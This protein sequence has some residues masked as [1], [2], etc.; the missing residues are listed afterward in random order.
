MC[1][2]LNIGKLDLPDLNSLLAL[3]PLDHDIVRLHICSILAT[4]SR[5]LRTDKFWYTGVDNVLIM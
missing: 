3:L 5:D 2:I 1:S 4:S